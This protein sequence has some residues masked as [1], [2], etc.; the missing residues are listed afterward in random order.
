MEL[1]DE[2][3]ATSGDYRNFWDADGS[4]YSHI[5]DPRTGRPLAYVGAAVTVLHERAVLADAWATAMTV[6]GP[7]AG[8]A[9]A[10][11][12]ELGVIFVRQGESGLTETRSRVLGERTLES[13]DGGEGTEPPR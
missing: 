3:V 7:E 4:R 11:E 10:D 2:S 8:T 6:L 1:G 5:I 9:L 12:L 13:L